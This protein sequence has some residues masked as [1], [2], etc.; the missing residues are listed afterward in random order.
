MSGLFRCRCALLLLAIAVALLAG[1]ATAS[2][3]D[4]TG[5]ASAPDEPEVT[6]LLCGTGDDAACPR[7]YVLRLSGENLRQAQRVVFLGGPSA[8]D[9]RAARPT[10]ASPHRLIVTVPKAARSGRLRV[11]ARSARS[12]P[13]PRLKVLP[14]PAPQTTSADAGGAAPVAG[15]S[16]GVFP[17]RGKHDLGTETNRFGGGRDH[18]GQ[19]ILTACGTPIVAAVGGV[20]TFARF[21]D[22]AGNYVV[23]KADDGTGQAYMHLRAPA[24]VDKGERVVA[25]QQLGIAGRTGR[26]SACML[27]FE[28]WTAPGW[29]TGGRPVDTMP[30]L[31]RWERTERPAAH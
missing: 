9:D 7:G 31:R 10:E 18:G 12:E 26:A 1:P 11:V 14:R 28:L 4:S 17:V 21:Q 27:H 24:T 19:D 3:H 16:G 15:A 25:G 22:R 5:G 20:V 13:G 2:A 6:E 30:Q 8:R 23:V 29:Y